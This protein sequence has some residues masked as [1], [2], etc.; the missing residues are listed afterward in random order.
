MKM[1]DRYYEYRES[2][3]SVLRHFHRHVKKL[4]LVGI[5]LLISVSIGFFA[6]YRWLDP[7]LGTT[8][9][10]PNHIVRLSSARLY[11]LFLARAIIDHQRQP[12][13]LQLYAHANT[14]IH[15]LTSYEV[16]F[17]LMVDLNVRKYAASMSIKRGSV[18]INREELENIVY[19]W[20]RGWNQHT[21]LT[22]EQ[23][24]L[25]PCERYAP[26]VDRRLPWR[27]FAFLEPDFNVGLGQ[28]P[29]FPYE[30]DLNQVVEFKDVP[31]ILRVAVFGFHR[32]DLS[33]DKIDV[34]E[35]EPTETPFS[36]RYKE[37]GA[38]YL[39]IRMHL[40]SITST[41]FAVPPEV[42]IELETEPLFQLLSPETLH[43][44][45]IAKLLASLSLFAIVFQF[46]LS[47][48]LDIYTWLKRE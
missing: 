4:L 9:S 46:L 28:H 2:I 47:V 12:E 44:R 19:E 31:E 14:K 23:F 11:L 48:P 41:G 7:F 5:A 43:S 35:L 17:F 27:A 30:I 8:L 37:P 16:R 29:R 15:E 33:S 3:Y 18:S 26:G 13:L 38:K 34:F 20:L 32:Y 10:F 39:V 25:T 6:Y 36:W 21:G 40:Y 1:T 22:R 24:S 45:W 42:W